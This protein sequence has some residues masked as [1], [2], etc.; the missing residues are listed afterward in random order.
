M[1]I[2]F[3]ITLTEKEIM[4]LGKI[5]FSF[6]FLNLHGLNQAVAKTFNP[7]TWGGGARVEAET[8]GSELKAS[9]AYIASSKSLSVMLWDPVSKQNSSTTKIFDGYQLAK[10]KIKKGIKLY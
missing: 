2:H 5:Y 1:F 4:Y 8:G 10:D 7:S 6:Y 3:E 9:L